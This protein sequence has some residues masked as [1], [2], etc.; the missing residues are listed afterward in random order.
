M[1]LT[2]PEIVTIAKKLKKDMF[3]KK[4]K[5]SEKHTPKIDAYLDMIITRGDRIIASTADMTRWMEDIQDGL[6]KME[7]RGVTAFVQ[8]K[9][10]PLK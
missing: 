4:I 7:E 1:S 3:V 6:K 2:I 5:F 8:T 10:N 9:E